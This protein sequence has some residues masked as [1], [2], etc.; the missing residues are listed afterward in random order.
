VAATIYDGVDATDFAHVTGAPTTKAFPA[1]TLAVP[2]DRLVWV[3]ATI[4]FDATGA[5][6]PQNCRYSGVMI[7]YTVTRP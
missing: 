7:D 3:N 5:A 4:A 2:V 1:F 6:T